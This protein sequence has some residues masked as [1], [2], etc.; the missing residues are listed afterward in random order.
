M[1]GI[2]FKL[3]EN[4]KA[5]YSV[6][7]NNMHNFDESGFH[8][9]VIGTMKAVTGAKRHARPELILPGNRK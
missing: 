4:T 8:M 7:D 2:W 9:G 1:I 3:V 5:K 6:H